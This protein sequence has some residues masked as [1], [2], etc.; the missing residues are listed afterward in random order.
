MEY[1]SN[2][3][4]HRVEDVKTAIQ[5]MG[6]DAFRFHILK[7]PMPP[8]FDQ[9]DD[10][11]DYDRAVA[12]GYWCVAALPYTSRELIGTFFHNWCY[13]NDII[14]SNGPDG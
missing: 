8:S 3:Q 14:A 1:I 12:Q 9:I 6:D 2:F 4:P 13:P 5:T 10:Y 11:Y 7:C